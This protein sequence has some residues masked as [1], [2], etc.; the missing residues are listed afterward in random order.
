MICKSKAKVARAYVVSNR[1]IRYRWLGG[2]WDL[3]FFH[4]LRHT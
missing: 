2:F 3:F 1:T 4:H